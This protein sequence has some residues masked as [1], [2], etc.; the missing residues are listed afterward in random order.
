MKCWGRFFAAFCIGMG[1][2]AILT[3]SIDLLFRQT[4]YWGRE[5]RLK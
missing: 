4:G 3:F 1:P 2:K 5:K